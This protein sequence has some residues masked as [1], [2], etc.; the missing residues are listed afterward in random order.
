M[1]LILFSVYRDG[2]TGINTS[3]ISSVHIHMSLTLL[4]LSSPH[5]QLSSAS[6]QHPSAQRQHGHSSIH[7]PRRAPNGSKSQVP[8]SRPCLSGTIGHVS[9]SQDPR[10]QYTRY[11][12]VTHQYTRCESTSPGTRPPNLMFVLSHAPHKEGWGSGLQTST[13]PPRTHSLPGTTGAYGTW[14][15]NRYRHTRP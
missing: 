15:P 8:K 10:T 11:T 2:I 9:P 6:A 7:P 1:K 5:L 3:S 12:A 14:R 4:S 13:L